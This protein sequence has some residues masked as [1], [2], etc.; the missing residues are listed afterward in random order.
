MN[1]VIKMAFFECRCLTTSAGWADECQ[2]MQ[3]CYQSILKVKY[4]ANKTPF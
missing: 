4:I 2:C 3:K 1:E